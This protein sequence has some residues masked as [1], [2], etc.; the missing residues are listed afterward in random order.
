M[1]GI[2]T[3]RRSRRLHSGLA[4]AMATNAIEAFLPSA[5][6]GACLALV[7]AA[8]APGELWM[9]PRASGRS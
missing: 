3:L 1:I 9:L 8:C 7:T 5:G 6:A 4:D 2:E